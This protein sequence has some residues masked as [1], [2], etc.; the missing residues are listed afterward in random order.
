MIQTANM[1]VGD[2]SVIDHAWLNKDGSLVGESLTLSCEITG[3]VDAEE[4]VVIDFSGCKKEIKRI[5]DDSEFAID[6][7][8]V[9]VDGFGL[10]GMEDVEGRER[11]CLDTSTT[12]VVASVDDWYQVIPML[13][14]F[15]EDATE[16]EQYH[17]HLKA[18]I[19]NT[20]HR[21]LNKL[22]YPV[23]SVLVD[24]CTNFF[25]P[26]AVVSHATFKYVHGLRSSTSY[27]CQN[28]GHGHRSF[29]AT[30]VEATH[31]LHE[32]ADFYQGIFAWDENVKQEDPDLVISYTSGR[33]NFRM[34]TTSKV[35]VFPHETTIENLASAVAKEYG[36][37][38]R[39]LGAT[40][41]WVSE[42]LSKGAI[43]EL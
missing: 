13:G 32:I 39:E 22:G 12:A 18:Y 14:V 9:V 21:E 24:F 1:Y 4:Q 15:A 35:T 23:T 25:L 38:L 31:L 28:V 42:G 37:R 41:L 26:K 27:G 11:K 17:A 2:I 6:H 3:E 40:R 43:V 36:D 8:T 10:Y 16:E 29:I 5:I 20:L 30:D 34:A 7:R 19:E 33:G